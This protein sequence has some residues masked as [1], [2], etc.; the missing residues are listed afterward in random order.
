MYGPWIYKNTPKNDARFLLGQSGVKTLI[1]IGINPSTAEPNNLDNTLTSVRRFAR[2]LGYDS[3]MMLNVYPQ[4]ATN[5]NDLHEVC[6]ENLH[7]QNLQALKDFLQ[8]GSYDVWA[9]WGTLISK[10]KYLPRC[11]NDMYEL[12]KVHDMKWYT[13][14]QRT[15]AG[16]P[17]H[18]LY[19]R[20]ETTLE[21]FDVE[22]YLQSIAIQELS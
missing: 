16:H 9:G 21:R 6:D 4:R 12:M 22:A 14:G 5:P 18:P 13:M 1:C 7:A 8:E 19:L 3:W 2:D 15:K 17:H 20:K 10:R 11:L